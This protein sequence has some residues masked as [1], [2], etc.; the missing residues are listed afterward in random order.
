[1]EG[2]KVYMPLMIGDW[3]KGTRGMKA[4]VRGVYLNLLLYQWDNGYIPSD[5]E[6]LC[7]IDP[8]LPKVWDKIKSKFVE[9]AP[10][11]LQNKKS[12]E[13]RNFWSKQKSN[14]KKGGRPKKENPNNN[15]TNNPNTNLHNDIDL[16]NDIVV[17]KVKEGS[18]TIR[19]NV[20]RETDSEIVEEKL[21]ELDEIY[22]DQQRMKWSH[23]DF[24]FELKT[25]FE[26]V[27][28]SPEFY[29]NHQHGGIRLA[30]QKQLRESKNRKQ[31][32]ATGKNKHQQHTSKLA[33]SFAQTYGGVLGSGEDG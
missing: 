20:A 10:G 17:D 30:F 11:Q 26:K 23:L 21:L 28:G 19:V 4:E 33:A 7:L 2:Q 27:R 8:E 3:L 9:I 31:H 32:N 15:P 13:V 29:R 24:D 14:G 22:I 5:M 12:E 16:D 18:E 1:M 25:F 6:E